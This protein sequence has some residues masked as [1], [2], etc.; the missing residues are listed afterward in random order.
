LAQ[1][2]KGKSPKWN[3][4]IVPNDY[5]VTILL[6]FIDPN[7]S[8]GKITVTHNR[9]PDA[10]R[11]FDQHETRSKNKNGKEDAD[12]ATVATA[13]KKNDKK[14]TQQEKESRELIATNRA[15]A[16]RRPPPLAQIKKK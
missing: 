3:A 15:P 16:K 12:S 8:G 1:R 6:P 4:N 14:I 10:P 11:S 5:W 2:K 9:G 7:V 13:A